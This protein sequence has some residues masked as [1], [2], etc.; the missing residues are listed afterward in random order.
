MAGD[1]IKVTLS[2][3]ESCSRSFSDCSKTIVEI[4]QSLATASAAMKPAWNDPAQTAFEASMEEM[5]NEFEKAYACLSAMSSYSSYVAE[6]YKAT[7][8]SATSL[9]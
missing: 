1:Q 9:L 3:M 2:A 4:A 5:V 6:L 7:D 8:Q